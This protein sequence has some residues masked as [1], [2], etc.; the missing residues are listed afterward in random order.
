MG[1]VSLCLDAGHYGKYNRSPVVPEFYESDFNWKFHLLLKKYL[2]EYGFKV[3]TTRERQAEDMDLYERGRRAKG[4]S[5]P[6]GQPGKV[7][8]IPLLMFP[9]TAAEMRS[10]GF[11]HSASV[12]SWVRRRKP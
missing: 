7:P 8:T 9:S 5:M 10:A 1:E 11:W 6:T 12:R 4:P 3:T 2:E